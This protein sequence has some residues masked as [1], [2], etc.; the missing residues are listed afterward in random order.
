M[1]ASEAM[2]RGNVDSLMKVVTALDVAGLELIAEG[3]VSRTGGRG[4]RLK[5]SLTAARPP[6]PASRERG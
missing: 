5:E 2:I 1:E 3:E 6:V 4:V